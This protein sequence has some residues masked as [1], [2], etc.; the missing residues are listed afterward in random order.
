M[1]VVEAMLD[2]TIE[3]GQPRPEALG[4]LRLYGRGF[5][6]TGKN[7]GQTEKMR[8]PEMGRTRVQGGV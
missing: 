3:V 7:L 4:V 2:G 8:E 1:D 5:L 6:C